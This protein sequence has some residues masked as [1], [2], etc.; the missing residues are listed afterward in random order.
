MKVISPLIHIAMLSLPLIGC[1]KAPPP[2][3]PPA[4]MAP[5]S[6]AAVLWAAQ[7]DRFIE[8][9][10]RAQPTSAVAAGRHEF[11]GKMDDLSAEGLAREVSRLHAVRDALSAV[12]P[13][14]LPSAERFERDYALRAVDEDLFWREKARAP[15]RNPAWY[16]GEIDPEVYVG[17][18]YAP[19]DVRLKAFIAY[20]AQLPKIASEI[21]AN[22][23]GPLPKSFVELAVA[24]F[25]GY[26]DFFRDDVKLI[27]KDVKDADL[28]RQ[29]ADVDV[30]A[31]QAMKSL[32]DY[33]VS[34]R[35]TANT[36]FALGKELF[37]AMLA[38]AERVNIPIEQIEAAGRADLERNTAALKS[39]CERYFPKSSLKACVAREESHKP[40][41]GSVVA[42]R[43]D[44]K[45]LREFIVSHQVV[46]IPNADEASIA[47]APP[48]N[49]AN[50]AYMVPPGPYEHGVNTMIYISPPDPKW[51]AAEQAAYI[52]SRGELMNTIVHEVW[53]GHFLQYLHSNSNPSKLEALFVS[54][55]FAEGWAHYGEELMTEMGFADGDPEL[56]IAQIKD[57]LERDVRLLSSI[58]MHTRG[59]TQAESERM[60]LETAFEDKATARQQAARGTYDPHYLAYTLGKLMIRKLRADW[61]TQRL[62]GKTATPTEEHQLWREFHDKFL[63]YGGPAIP[64]LREELLGAEGALL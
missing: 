28:Q 33:F 5:A 43:Q 9:Y 54:T 31:V 3:P 19:L 18:N 36:D 35:R 38:D 49:R 41:G 11:D 46:S 60:F 4:A 2:A 25:G 14:S 30:A 8:E 42:A 44:L 7:R 1:Q 52:D 63:S 29:L 24:G 21:R 40:A 17:H 61:V 58:G 50:G 20:A 39:E 51:T 16:I 64:R 32:Q 57:A 34:Q 6:N 15:F 55:V 62:A 48:Y 56:H 10:F 13:L 12:D 27:F 47:D 37:A 23:P 26:A 53:P 59:M 45:S 22:L